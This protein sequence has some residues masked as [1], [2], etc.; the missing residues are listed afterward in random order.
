MMHIEG[1]TRAKTIVSSLVLTTVVGFHFLPWRTPVDA[2]FIVVTNAA[3]ERE[4]VMHRFVKI[5]LP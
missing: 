2:S 1:N 3:R 4:A 5:A